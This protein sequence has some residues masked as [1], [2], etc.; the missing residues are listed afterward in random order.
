MLRKLLSLLICIN[1]I[2]SQSLITFAQDSEYEYTRDEVL[3][4]ENGAQYIDRIE[5]F[6]SQLSYDEL[7]AVKSRLTD[8]TLSRDI[9][10][11]SDTGKILE[12]LSVAISKSI[13][14]PSYQAPSIEEMRESSEILAN[15]QWRMG[16]ELRNMLRLTSSEWFR[17]SEYKENGNVSF[18]IQAEAPE[19]VRIHGWFDISKYNYTQNS[20]DSR[21]E[22]DISAFIES[23]IPWDEFA[24]QGETFLDLISKDGQLYA[25][26]K[27]INIS[28]N[29]LE[30]NINILVEKLDELA[31]SNTYLTLEDEFSAEALMALSNI[32]LSEIETYITKL[33]TAPML[34][35]YLKTDSGYL[36]KPTKDLCNEIKELMSIFDPF[37]G[38]NCSDAQY[39]DLLQDFYESW[40][41]ISLTPWDSHNINV[42]YQD[43][44]TNINMDLFW[45]ENALENIS[46]KINTPNI[47]E[48]EYMTFEW[49]FWESINMDMKV[50]DTMSSNMEILFHTN[51]S[52]SD[53]EMT[54]LMNNS[55]DLSVIYRSNYLDINMSYN[56]AR[57]NYECN[58]GGLLKST[59]INLTGKCSITSEII[60]YLDT[61]SDTLDISGN[62]EYN[63]IWNDEEVDI[64]IS[65]TSGETLSVD[66][67]L[68]AN[69]KRIYG[70]TN[71][72]LSPNNTK[73]IDEF[74]QEL[75]ETYY[76]N[77]DFNYDIDY[78]YEL[79]ET[80]FDDYYQECYNYSDGS[81][82]CT[83]NYDDGKIESCNKY[84]EDEEYDCTYYYYIVTTSKNVTT[85]AMEAHTVQTTMTREK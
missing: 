50:E 29:S 32:G 4:I 22:W 78:E 35:A 82:Y 38:K 20:F 34:E 45:N 11:N 28:Q 49:I 56:D 79:I 62:L 52:I 7:Q 19:N 57:E 27:E 8:L 2:F 85:T 16:D 72:I 33:E 77:D 26:F 39:D 51:G 66:T 46:F 13:V 1:I 61:G 64:K 58:I 43:T 31:E 55:M 70:E 60:S 25:L 84:S 12:F 65:I 69:N 15:L 76:N 71:E 42:S 73:N 41:Q 59:R 6:I 63:K 9:D 83:N 40:I 5:A 23:F 67:S 81:S 53:L 10:Y 47:A 44:N 74:S 30:E 80:E 37:S 24:F 48:S 18:S 54:M 21:F 75:Y 68:E 17:L 36:L 3:S 14:S